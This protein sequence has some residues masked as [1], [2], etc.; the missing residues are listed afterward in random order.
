MPKDVHEQYKDDE[1]QPMPNPTK[2]TQGIDAYTPRASFLQ[3]CQISNTC[4]LI[5]QHL[6]SFP[7]GLAGMSMLSEPVYSLH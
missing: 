6:R 2:V 1:F 5:L 7:G 3:Q 4:F